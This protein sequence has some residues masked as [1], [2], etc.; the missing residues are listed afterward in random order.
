MYTSIYVNVI[1]Y[2]LC[3]AGYDVCTHLLRL[4]DAMLLNS[5]FRITSGIHTV[6]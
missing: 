3:S 1:I 5:T 6:G 2:T 4:R